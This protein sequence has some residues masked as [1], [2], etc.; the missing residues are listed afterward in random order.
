MI[1]IRYLSCF[2]VLAGFVL[3]PFKVLAGMSLV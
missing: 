2:S 3:L 1:N